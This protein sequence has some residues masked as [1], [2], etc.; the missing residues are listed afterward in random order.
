M[1]LIESIVKSFQEINDEKKIDALVESAA[2]FAKNCNVE[3]EKDFN[4]HH[5]R[6]LKLKKIDENP[7]T[8]AVIDFSQFYRKEFKILYD[9][10]T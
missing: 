4:K 10:F 5:R 3:P 1:Q 7:E 2:S 9:V 8:A 6:R